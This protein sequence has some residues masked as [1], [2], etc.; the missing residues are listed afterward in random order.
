MLLCVSFGVQ[1]PAALWVALHISSYVLIYIFVFCL[2]KKKNLGS[3]VE[4][5]VHPLCVYEL[6]SLS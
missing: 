2:L 5:I 3:A 1:H 4:L 6:C